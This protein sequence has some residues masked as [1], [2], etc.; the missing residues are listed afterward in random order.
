MHQFVGN[1]LKRSEV[2]SLKYCALL[3]KCAQE[4]YTVPYLL[5]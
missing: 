4:S 1:G 5:T 3:E 2:C